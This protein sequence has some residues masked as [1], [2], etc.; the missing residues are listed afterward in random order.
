M[1]TTGFA[2]VK[3]TMGVSTDSRTART[4]SSVPR[5]V[6]P[7][8]SARSVARWITGPSASGSE[9]GT[10]TSSTAAPARDSAIEDLD[11][12][13]AI[14]IAG[15][16]VRNDPPLTRSG[17]RVLR[18]ASSAHR[19]FRR[20]GRIEDLLHAQ[21]VLVAASRQ[22]DQEHLV[23]AASRAPAGRRGRSRATTR[24]PPGS[25]PRARGVETPRA[26]RCRRSTCIPRARSRAAT[27]APARRPRS[28]GPPKSNA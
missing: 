5:S 27:R 3:S 15:R 16:A 17:E 7:A 23:A 10:P 4:R 8:A 25:P 20:G 14:R 22:V 28:P 2:Y 11:G 24:A 18:S 12:R 26:R 21:H 1:R 13:L 9:N 6:M 19:R